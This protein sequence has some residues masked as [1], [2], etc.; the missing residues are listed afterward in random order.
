[1]PSARRKRA[2]NKKHYIQN[3]KE[4]KTKAKSN[5]S[6]DPEKKKA[7]S[8]ARYSAD[9]T[10]KKAASCA[11]SKKSY[12]KNP[13]PKIHSSQAYYAN[14]KES[15]CAYRRA[16]YVLVEPKCEVQEQYAKEILGHLLIKSEAKF[17]LI[18]AFIR[19]QKSKMPRVMRQA[20]C[21]VAAKR[22]LNKLLQT[23]REYVGS[24]FKACRLIKANQ[25]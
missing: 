20:V 23:R 15:R 21:R 1:M 5:Y 19:Q 11:Y 13:T 7:A 10:K 3:I 12:A 22:L 24:L 2:Q 8:K 16:R 25:D 9:S 6:A 18:A 4:L 14:N 17:Q